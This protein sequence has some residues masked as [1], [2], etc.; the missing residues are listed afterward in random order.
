MPFLFLILS[1]FL[2]QNADSSL[3]AGDCKTAFYVTSCGDK[4]VN[5]ASV[6]L[7]TSR[8][9]K[10]KGNT[11]GDGFIRFNLC[12]LSYDAFGNTLK[13]AS[14]DSALVYRTYDEKLYRISDD[15]LLDDYRYLRYSIFGVEKYVSYGDSIYLYKA[16]DS[17]RIIK[18]DMKYK[19]NRIGKLGIRRVRNKMKI[20]DRAMR[21][22]LE[23][24]CHME[25]NTLVCPIN[26]CSL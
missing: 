2:S 21:G 11:G 10:F 1:F 12:L 23:G 19:S 6:T 18:M 14:G 24:K 15:E 22:F 8:M 17:Q 4:P 20:S 7:F 26:I 13:L 5:D 3:A 16:G 9:K 25:E